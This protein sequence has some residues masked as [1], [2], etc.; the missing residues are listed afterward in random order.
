MPKNGTDDVSSHK[1]DVVQHWD[2]LINLLGQYIYYFQLLCVFCCLKYNKNCFVFASLLKTCCILPVPNDGTVSS[3]LK[4]IVRYV[5]NLCCSRFTRLSS[6]SFVLWHFLTKQSLVT[7]V[8]PLSI[9]IC[10]CRQHMIPPYCVMRA[11]VTDF[12]LL[13]LH[14][15][16]HAYQLGMPQLTS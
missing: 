9:P 10:V 4:K 15:D 6:D 16:R 13:F 8:F 5:L 11:S 12:L 14:N 2:S 3:H 7:G 1:N